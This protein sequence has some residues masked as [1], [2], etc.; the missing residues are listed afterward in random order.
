MGHAGFYRSLVESVAALTLF[1]MPSAL[2][3]EP[4][5]SVAA[6]T[7]D[8][9]IASLAA[10]GGREI[11]SLEP[12]LSRVKV[13]AVV[14]ASVDRALELILRDTGYQAVAR[15]GGWRIVRRLPPS[16]RPN[17]VP[18]PVIGGEIIVTGG[19]QNQ[20]LARYPGSVTITLDTNSED[21]AAR[22]RD[23]DD[24]ARAIP[25]LQSTNFGEGRNKL[26]VRGIADSSFNGATQSP[27]SVYFGDAQLGFASP[28]PSIKLYD[29]ERIEILEGPQGTL[30]GSGAIGGIIRIE[31]KRPDLSRPAASVTVG[32]TLG[33]A[34][35]PGFDTAIIANFPIVDDTLGIRAV[36]YRT[37]DGG[38]LDL[39]DRGRLPNQ[40]DIEGARLAARLKLASWDVEVSGLTQNIDAKNSQYAETSPVKMRSAGLAQPFDS[41]IQVGRLVVKHD[42][43][44]SL[45]ILSSTALVR[46]SS[47]DTFDATTAAVRP[48]VYTIS[49]AASLFAQEVRLLRE[50]RNGGSWVVGASFLRASD[51]QAR[52]LGVP[53]APVELDEVTNITYA[54]SGFA[55]VTLP[56]DPRLQMTLGSRVTYSR[57]DGQPATARG[58]AP[59]V[60]GMPTTRVDPTLGVAWQAAPRL[61]LFGRLQTGYRTGGIA[62]ARGVGRVADF[63]PDSIVMGEVGVRRRGA[64]HHGPTL[65]LAASYADW[66]GIQADLISS[67]G[68]PY[69]V[70]LGNAQLV[71][72]EASIDWEIVRGLSAAGSMLLA[73]S[74]LTGQLVQQSNL[75]NQRLPDT[76]A[77][78]VGAGIRYRWLCWSAVCHA[79]ADFR[80]T[81]RSVLGP[82][83]LLDVSQGDYATVNAG[84]GLAIKKIDL[85]FNIENITN[86]RANQ[87]SYGNP[88]TISAHNQVAPLRPLSVRIG[89]AYSL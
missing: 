84:A 70:N 55:Q 1:L 30:Y 33:I 50:W 64:L 65:S 3:A 5:F 13:P 21:A 22:L 80:Y 58:L 45:R 37:R 53:D 77:F 51:A 69:T 10:Q 78:S 24:I 44:G 11:V 12:G 71:A 8:R 43:S 49:R 47:L 15:A 36:A 56:I 73:H 60:R 76:P 46:R 86:S 61:S 18:K 68:L 48:T 41:T 66:T 2:C 54:L 19:K 35:D 16:A 87:F 26:F 67:R 63:K 57:T 85:S 74:R 42:L 20:T 32:S 28:N 89:V 25:V 39:R 81:G 31:P 9:A 88:L 34:T 52:S 4:R 75:N 83:A 82:N 7:L 72:V 27:T 23:L 40:V 14:A 62:V 17:S 6:G 29:I 38:V 79:A 59:I